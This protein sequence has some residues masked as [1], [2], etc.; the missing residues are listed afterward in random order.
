M[1]SLSCTLRR[2]STGDCLRTLCLRPL[3]WCTPPD[4]DLVLLWPPLCWRGVT[5]SC[6]SDT[7]LV[8]LLRRLGVPR[9][10]PDDPSSVPCLG[11]LAPASEVHPPVLLFRGLLCSPLCRGLRP[12]SA[13]FRGLRSLLARPMSSSCLTAPSARLGDL[14]GDLLAWWRSC[15]SAGGSGL[16][17]GGWWGAC[18]RCGG[19]GGPPPGQ[20]GRVGGWL[21]GG[22]WWNW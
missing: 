4:S 18:T 2:S 16:R 1:L 20:G 11:L 8:C 7:V 6:T 22:P 9:V 21:C 17:G 19:G 12:A 13:E 14:F 3:C 15:S 5:S 10:C